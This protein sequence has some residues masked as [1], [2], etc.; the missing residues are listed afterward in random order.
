[1]KKNSK[2]FIADTATVNGDVKMGR[3]SSVWFSAVVRADMSSIE[4]GDFTNVQ[5]TCVVHVS[6]QKG[7]KIGS[8]VTMGHGAIV[9]SCDIGDNVLIGMNATVLHNTK[10]G[11]NCII[12]AGSVVPPGK[13]IPDNSMVMGVPAKVVREITGEEKKSIRENA[14]IYAEAAKCYLEGKPF[15]GK[16]IDIYTKDSE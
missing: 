2:N 12:A 9:H 11:S 8:Y 14:E 5:D 6:N 10:I 7:V 1:M 4:I 13:E 3:E 16:P 15:R